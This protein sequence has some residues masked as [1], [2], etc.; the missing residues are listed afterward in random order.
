MLI[1]LYLCI[2]QFCVIACLFALY[3]KKIRLDI[4]TM[5]II[6]INLI[7]LHIRDLGLINDIASVFIAIFTFIYCLYE[8]DKSIKRAIVN[9]VLYIIALS[10]I[11]LVCSI[12]VIFL[13]VLIHNEA[14]ILSLLNGLV[15]LVIMLLRSRLKGLSNL[16]NT[17]RHAMMI[18]IA[19][20]FVMVIM[21]LVKYKSYQYLTLEIYMVGVVLIILAIVLVKKWQESRIEAE[22]NKKE[23]AATKE[24]LKEYTSLVKGVKRQHHDVKNQI[25]AVYG[26]QYTADSQEQVKMSHNEYASFIYDTEKFE[27]LLLM[28]N[29][30][31][32]G[33]LYS[34]FCEIEEKGIKINHSIGMYSKECGMPIHELVAALGVIFDNAIEE[35]C[36]L[37]RKDKEIKLTIEETDDYIVFFVENIAEF[38]THKRMRE[39][40]QEGVSSKGEGRGIGLYNVYEKTKKYGFEAYAQ[41]KEYLGEK[42]LSVGMRKE[43]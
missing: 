5:C 23:L 26:L 3:G 40:F 20:C 9:N 16:V 27:K 28:P 11:Q 33:F 43:K 41:N 2:E 24:Y 13:R 19:I 36:K 35:T 42:W 8:F 12:P 21:L 31:L 4:H 39:I 22:E 17:K 18:P 6:V 7:T 38:M 15:L 10:L 32:S 37:E 14:L 29:K 34:K 1:N 25:S 30:I